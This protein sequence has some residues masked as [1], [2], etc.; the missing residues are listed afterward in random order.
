MP[1]ATSSISAAAAAIGAA[2]SRASI[3][4]NTGTGVG[5]AIKRRGSVNGSVAPSGTGATNLR[6]GSVEMGLHAL[7]QPPHQSALDGPSDYI[8]DFRRNETEAALT[9]ALEASRSETQAL[10]LALKQANEKCAETT[11]AYES[12]LEQLKEEG[13][14]LSKRDRE[15]FRSALKDVRDYEIYKEVMEAA[16]IRLQGELETYAAENANLKNHRHLEEKLTAKQKNFSEKYSKDLCATKKKLTEVE[17][18]LVAAEKQVKQLSKERDVAVS[19]LAQAKSLGS[20]KEGT[21]RVSSDLQ[22]AENDDLRKRL[23]QMEEKCKVLELEKESLMSANIQEVTSLRAAHTK[24]LEVIMN[25]QEESDSLR[26]QIAGFGGESKKD[27]R[28][29]TSKL[30]AAGSV[31][32]S[33]RL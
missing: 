15:R 17:S 23:A 2:A 16:M 21:L 11:K 5:S 29:N 6:R 30:A 27:N 1:N 3:S 32:S 22:Q 8:E 26:T 7:P 4:L 28:A 25:Y 14:M 24:A 12:L 31:R 19:T 33:I 18:K 20:Q 13:A 9:M 10:Q